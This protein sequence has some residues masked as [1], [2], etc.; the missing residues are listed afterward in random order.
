MWEPDKFMSQPEE[1]LIQQQ[2]ITYRVVNGKIHKE[3]VTRRY[4]GKDD[5][6]DSTTVEV[7]D[8]SG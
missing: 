7:L 5:Y 3:T 6:Q 2:R 8:V 1:G 4:M